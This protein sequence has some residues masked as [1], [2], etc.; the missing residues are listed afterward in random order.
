[1][2]KRDSE[3]RET[4]LDA[5]SWAQAVNIDDILRAHGEFLHRSLKPL[6]EIDFRNAEDFGQ[7]DAF[8]NECEGMCGV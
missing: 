7:M 8:G 6:E 5:A 2:F 1:M 3:W 4:K